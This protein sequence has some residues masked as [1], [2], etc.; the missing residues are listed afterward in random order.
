[1][2]PDARRSVAIPIGMAVGLPLAFARFS[3]LGAALSLI[4]AFFLL[5]VA[6]LTAVEAIRQSP[7]RQVLDVEPATDDH[8]G[9]AA[10]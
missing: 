2:S 4:P 5:L 7:S 3:L 8:E 10:A 9:R 6:A 1:M